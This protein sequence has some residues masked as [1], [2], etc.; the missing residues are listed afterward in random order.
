MSLGLSAYRRGTALLQPLARLVLGGRAKRGKEDPARLGERL[1]RSSARRPEGP[2]VWLHGASVGE[3]LSL[4]PLIERLRIERPDVTPLIT[5]G[6]VTAAE[7][8]ALRLPQGAIHQYAPVDTPGAARR[9][10]DTWRPDLAIFC[11]GEL[12]PNLIL[13]ARRRGVRLALVSARM[14]ERSARGWSRLRKAAR[15]VLAAYDVILAQD[16]A[17]RE[18]L[19]SLGAIVAGLA[20]FKLAGEAPPYDPAELERLRKAAGD[21]PI[22][23]AASTHA[24]EEQLVV[25]AKDGADALLVLAPRHPARGD[26]VAQA[27]EGE[28]LARRSRG[29]L[30][31]LETDVYLADT[32]GE[33]G[34]FFRLAD[35]VVMGGSLV[36]KVGGHNPLEPARLGRPVITGFDVSNWTEVYAGLIAAGGAVQADVDTLPERLHA[37]LSAPQEARAAGARALAFAR[38]AGD[39]VAAA[40]PHLL[41][42]LPAR[43]A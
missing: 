36:G 5:A 4:L 12:W 14:T 22:I 3:S 15:Q 42:L 21:R 26:E 1:G 10:L 39:P 7:L 24:G 17:S 19:E 32:L 30:P 16:E 33:L 37:W 11:E 40:W 6:T 27:L 23:L 41:P 38:S 20:N 13:Q 31:T 8:L 25:D 43:G 9:F 29:E 34:L 18:R 2:L 28:R 35:I